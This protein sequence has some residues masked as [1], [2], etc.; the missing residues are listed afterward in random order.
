M[1]TDA[2]NQE[3]EKNQTPTHED[4]N[5]EKKF[6]QQQMNEIISTRVNEVKSKFADYDALKEKAIKVDALNT[7]VAKK[8]EDLNKVNETLT[9]TYNSL[10]EKIPEDKRTLIPDELT[11]SQ[12]LSYISKNM[13]I[14]ISNSDKGIVSVLNKT[15][16]H[17]PIKKEEVSQ[18]IDP[19]DF[20][21]NPQ[22][23]KEYLEKRKK[24]L[25]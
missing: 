23:A 18:N 1:P 22:A 9:T 6:T 2:E 3:I 20:V 19:A 21:R 11:V 12:K 13:A 8:T 16:V 24:G 5:E 17:T 10:L 4:K 15:E 7:D 25:L 14:L